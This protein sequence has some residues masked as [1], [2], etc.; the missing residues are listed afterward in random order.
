MGFTYHIDESRGCL[1]ARRFGR[2]DIEDLERSTSELV[3]V[4][5]EN[6]IRK[7]LNDLSEADFSDISANEFYRYSNTFKNELRGT[8]IKMA[9]VAGS[10]INFG[11]ARMFEQFVGWDDLRVFRDPDAAVGWLGI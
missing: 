5:K 9:L 11:T 10:D 7:V 6:D 3:L 8:G 4:C 2:L 1:F